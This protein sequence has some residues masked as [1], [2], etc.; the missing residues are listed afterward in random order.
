MR[1]FANISY[2]PWANPYT[3]PASTGKDFYGA[4]SPPQPVYR[5][6]VLP[7]APTF[8]H[9]GIEQVIEDSSDDDSEAGM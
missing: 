2:S 6:I 7:P 1:Q 4:P 5:R 3:G 9:P 8:Y